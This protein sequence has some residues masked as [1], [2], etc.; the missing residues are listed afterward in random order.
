MA[1]FFVK[2]RTAGQRAEKM[3]FRVRAAPSRVS[4]SSMLDRALSEKVKDR[5]EFHL[6]VRFLRWVTKCSQFLSNNRREED[7]KA[8]LCDYHALLP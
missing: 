1:C 4:D 7:L 8:E 3:A 5:S 6:G 2:V